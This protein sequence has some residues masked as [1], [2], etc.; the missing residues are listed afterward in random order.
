MTTENQNLCRSTEK[1]LLIN[2]CG[3][4]KGKSSSAFGMMI[5]TLGWGGRV[6]ILQF[7]KSPSFETGEMLFFKQ[8]GVERVLFE[9]TGMGCFADQAEQKKLAQKALVRMEE[10]LAE[11]DLDLLILDELNIAVHLDL[12]SVEQVLAALNKRN[13]ALNVC[14][15]GRY[16]KPE[17]LSIC[18]L[19]SEVNEVA[20]P[21]R[22]GVPARK[23]IDY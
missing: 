19:I 12:I 9:A 10:L 11:E 14:I 4:G 17:I 20:H 15:T 8:L 18:D 6:G 3:N 23:G 1:G 7:V 22:K 21:C 16:A 2:L 13:P 5:R